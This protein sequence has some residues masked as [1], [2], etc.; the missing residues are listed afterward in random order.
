MRGGGCQGEDDP[1]QKGKK[2]KQ[3]S[4][5]RQALKA[6]DRDKSLHLFFFFFTADVIKG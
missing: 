2:D 3:A 5:F 6:S 4:T 1:T